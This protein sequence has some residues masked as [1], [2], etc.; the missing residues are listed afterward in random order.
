MRAELLSNIVQ[1]VQREG[2]S[3]LIFLE[4]PSPK[5]VGRSWNQNFTS[6][7]DV[8]T[9]LVMGTLCMIV[10]LEVAGQAGISIERS[11][12]FWSGPRSEYRLKKS[13]TWKSAN[14]SCNFPLVSTSS[15]CRGE[16]HLHH[17]AYT[18]VI[19]A[20]SLIMRIRGV[21]RFSWMMVA[22]DPTQRFSQIKTRGLP[23]AVHRENI[24]RLQS[25]AS[26]R[27]RVNVPHQVLI[28][29]QVVAL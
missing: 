17:A 9:S 20:N 26:S 23:P 18:R 7:D 2:T 29:L 22:T 13:T 19:P 12:K 28:I 24:R 5:C 21:S 14:N 15:T 10:S 8:K 1:K 6:S 4:Q 11:Q 27:L 3:F 16:R 25:E